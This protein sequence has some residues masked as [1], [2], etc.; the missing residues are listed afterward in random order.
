[1]PSDEVEF[2]DMSLEDIIKQ[3]L[4]DSK[5][6]FPS[7]AGDIGFMTIA[8]FGEA[9]E[10]ANL[11]KKG[12]RGDVEL[13]DSQYLRNLAMELTDTFIYLCNIAGLMHI[14]LE[15]MY[16]IKRELNVE[17][18]GPRTDQPTGIIQP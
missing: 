5:D 14:D 2:V 18:F 12:I 9:G 13:S 16:Q 10:F 3:C 8:M 11:V 15:K 7:T 1:M 6:W 17:R 4:E